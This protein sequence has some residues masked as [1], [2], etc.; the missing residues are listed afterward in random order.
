MPKIPTI[1]EAMDEPALFGPFFQG[2]EWR[3]WKA[4]IGAIYGLP[5]SA[6]LQAVVQ[7]HAHRDAPTDRV[8]EA[9]L[10]VGRRGGKSRVTAFMAVYTAAFRN[11]APHLAPGELARIPVVAADMDQAGA[12][13]GYVRGF[14]D[15]IPHL[16]GLLA[17]KPTAT[18][19]AFR[20]RCEIVVRA[21]TFRGLRSRPT[22]LILCD[23]IALWRN[24]DSRNPDHEILRALMP[25]MLTIP[26]AM[27]VGLS[28]PYARRGVLW[29][30]YK[31]HFGEA[32]PRVFVWQAATLDMNP[33]ADREEIA[34]AYA[35]DPV[36]AAAEY[37]GE[38]RSDLEAFVSEEV[39]EAAM[40]GQ[41]T[42]RPPQDGI[43]YSAF[44]DPCGGGPDSFA[45][46]IAH[47]EGDRGIL[48]RACDERV[49]DGLRPADIVAQY[50]AILKSYRCTTVTGDRYGGSWPGDEFARH[51]ISYVD[52]EQHKSELYL[53]FLPALISERVSLLKLP[54]LAS[55]LT[56]LDRKT[57]RMGKDSVDHPPGGHDDLANAVA[58]VL[59]PL[60][61]GV[62]DGLG[63]FRYLEQQAGS[64]AES[65]AVPIPSGLVPIP[66]GSDVPTPE[67]APS[68]WAGRVLP[69]R[70][71][72]R[73]ERQAAMDRAEVQ[74]RRA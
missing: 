61:G 56:A 7:Q 65:R 42:E 8:R 38:F 74:R 4:F 57:S 63:F 29:D 11:Y 70:V 71:L 2:P 19:V 18:R 10:A 27:L 49:T 35:D 20:T 9:W 46:A 52:A 44:T 26:G 13:F 73:E 32:N 48:D 67:P 3:S 47:K 60:V 50:A 6:R 24:E 41:P 23:E 64:A 59:A 30:R 45:L 54:R 43:T 37:G 69:H 12:I 55:Q 36:A 31:Q 14:L 21:A 22:P 66:L 5:M 39:V 58:G 53:A 34:R 17:G 15:N 40:A 33:T 51:G 72:T 68:Q 1:L 25:G 28:S 62:S 16:R